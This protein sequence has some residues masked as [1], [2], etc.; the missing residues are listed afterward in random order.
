MD[1]EGDSLIAPSP[2]AGG[3]R[4]RAAISDPQARSA[5]CLRVGD[6]GWLASVRATPGS[7]GARAIFHLHRA[8]VVLVQRCTLVPC[9]AFLRAAHARP[10]VQVQAHVV[11][12]AHAPHRTLSANQ[13]SSLANFQRQLH[14]APPPAPTNQEREANAR[15]DCTTNTKAIRVEAAPPSLHQ[16]QPPQIIA[17]RAP[18]HSDPASPSTP[19]TTRIQPLEASS[20][21][22][23]LDQTE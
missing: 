2:V 5:P 18:A 8:R 3:P 19:Q 22:A 16:C 4:E 13:F 23:R 20:A 6:D 15:A 17:T 7:Q 1:P 21:S 10:R 12:G 9:C 14:P 11:G